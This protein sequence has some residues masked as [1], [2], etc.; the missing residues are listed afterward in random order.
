[1][2]NPLNIGMTNEEAMEFKALIA[3]SLVRLKKA[4][5][6]MARDQIEIERLKTETAAILADIQ[7]K[8]GAFNVEAVF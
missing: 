6:Q 8:A 7:R 5:E 2:E 3:D 4:N 1:M